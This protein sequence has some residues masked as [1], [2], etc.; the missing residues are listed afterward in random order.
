MRV[1]WLCS[2]YPHSTDPLDGD[3]VERHAK[4]LATQC[5]VDV[6][7]VVQ[8]MPL[9][10]KEVYRTEQRQHHNLYAE[11]YTVPAPD[12]GI[13]Q[14]DKLLFHQRYTAVLK[15]AVE[16]YIHTNGKP[17]LV[18]VH[19]PVKMGSMAMWLKKKY[20]IPYVV[21]EHA[22]VY[23]RNSHDNYFE[24]GI[25]YKRLTKKTF[26]HADAVTSV[27]D[28]L[29]KVL[30]ELFALQQKYLIR[31]SVDTALFYPIQKANPVK[32]FVHVSMMV[33]FKNVEG[34]LKALS[35]LHMHRLD[36]EMRF[37]GP[38]N[39][40]LIKRSAELG[41]SSRVAWM[42]ALPYTQVAKEMQQADA[43]VHFSKYEN[44]PCVINEALCCGIPVIASDVGGISELIHPHNGMMVENGNEQELA[45]VLKIFLDN[46]EKF[47]QE[48]ISKEATAQFNYEAVGKVFVEMYK[49]LLGQF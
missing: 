1:L 13:V 33:P 23:F 35:V 4:S 24:R 18:H 2:W 47:N 29:M 11:I 46:P 25:Y 28:C 37:I 43:L 48:S 6:I 3:F 44:L 32:R 30:D 41:L 22:T 19:V 40:E 38:A 14:L 15:A 49:K 17:D 8:N 21:T 7:H 39:D 10:K 16:K 45:N 9:Q 31:N 5:A 26:E 42:G 27:S 20:G 36:W 12:T 34:I